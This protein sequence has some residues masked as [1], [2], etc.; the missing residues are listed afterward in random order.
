M[1]IRWASNIDQRLELYRDIPWRRL[2]SW[3]RIEANGKGSK[4]ESKRNESTTEQPE[5][6]VIQR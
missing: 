6:D 2:K 5:N 1:R 4:M 3:D